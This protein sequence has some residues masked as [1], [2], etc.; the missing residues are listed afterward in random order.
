MIAFEHAFGVSKAQA[1]SALSFSGEAFWT[2]VPDR[3]GTSKT[4]ARNTRIFALTREEDAV[5]HALDLGLSPCLTDDQ[6]LHLL[7]CRLG[8]VHTDVL[9][10]GISSSPWPH[11][12]E[13]E[14][15]PSEL[16]KQP[17]VVAVAY[18]TRSPD[19]FMTV[20]FFG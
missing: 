18:S 11:I 5:I 9:G 15:I 7:P 20:P 3:R 14:P 8:D 10:H 17:K 1:H 6:V 12:L 16:R 19:E 4:R 13:C 2:S